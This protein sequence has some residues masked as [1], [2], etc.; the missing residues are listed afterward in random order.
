MEH[1]DQKDGGSHTNPATG[2]VDLQQGATTNSLSSLATGRPQIPVSPPQEVTSLEQQQAGRDLARQLQQIAGGAS[3]SSPPG[4]GMGSGRTTDMERF[5]RFINGRDFDF[6]RFL[7][8]KVL[9][10]IL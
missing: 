5:Q 10:I 7:S 4:G 3:V 9:I 1:F 6:L 2:S 8:Y